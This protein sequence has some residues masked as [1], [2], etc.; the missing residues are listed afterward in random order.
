M[1]GLFRAGFGGRPDMLVASAGTAALTDYP[2]DPFA[3]QVM[4]QKGIDISTHRARQ[5]DEAM[6]YN[7]D[8]VVV[9]ERNHLDWIEANFP[10][11]RGRVFLAGHWG[12]S[13]IKEVPDPFRAPLSAFEEVHDQ[14]A[15]CVG[16][17]LSKLRLDK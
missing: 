15:V 1:E 2:A 4:A 14:L 9:M 13:R 17:W 10:A 3:V 16:Q 11:A 6:L 12:K 8:L 7:A 5:V